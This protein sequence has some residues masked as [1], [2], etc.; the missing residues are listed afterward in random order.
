[1]H[2]AIAI[3]HAAI[4]N[5]F[6]FTLSLRLPFLAAYCTPDIWEEGIGHIVASRRGP[7]GKVIFADFLLDVHCLGIKNLLVACEKTAAFE[8]FLDKL[9]DNLG[10]DDCD[11]A[12]ARK[13]L[14]EGVAYARRLGFPPSDA[15]TSALRLLHDADPALCPETFT[16]GKDGM[17]FYTS[18]PF[19]SVARR[20]EIIATLE[21]SCGKDGF[22]FMVHCGDAVQDS[23]GNWS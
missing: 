3:K 1:L 8:R 10:L 6:D 5:P 15:A 13:L 20:Q 7:N 22:H 17:P 12:Y 19:E 18:G 23:D 21:A 14:D 11:A 16:F 2:A 4:M 9:E